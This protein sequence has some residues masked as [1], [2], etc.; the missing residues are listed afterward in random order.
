MARRRRRLLWIALAAAG[1]HGCTCGAPPDGGRDAGDDVEDAGPPQD[2]G[3]AD[4]GEDDGGGG[5]GGDDAGP[6]DA[7]DAG[8][9]DVDAGIPAGCGDGDLDPGEECDDGAHLAC[10][11]CAPQCKVEHYALHV[12]A[13]GG[14]H[15]AR[16]IQ[17]APIRAVSAP[18][19]S[20]DDD[21]GVFHDDG[22]QTVVNDLTDAVALGVSSGACTIDVKASNAAA[23]GAAAYVLI[24]RTGSF[25][26]MALEGTEPVD[27]PVASVSFELG[28][29]LKARVADGGVL[30]V[31]LSLDCAP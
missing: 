5:D 15:F 6:G 14:V 25:P 10:D 3:G 31:D 26:I 12:D 16:R 27:I 24:E 17:G 11:G 29:A 13:D 2:D 9:D 7:A 20:I 18:I 8:G 21:V 4:P 28:N 30:P 23:A 22:C 1:V 19:R